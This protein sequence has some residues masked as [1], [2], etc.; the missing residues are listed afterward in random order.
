M[1]AEQWTWSQTGERFRSTRTA[2]DNVRFGDATEENPVCR[3]IPDVKKP[4]RLRQGFYHHLGKGYQVQVMRPSDDELQVFDVS[5]CVATA[6][7]VAGGPATAVAVTVTF[8]EG[9]KPWAEPLPVKYW[10][11][12]SAA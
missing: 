12:L 4:C 3:R 7:Q 10:P 8:C 1:T 5:E 2:Q 6:V 9:R 11:E